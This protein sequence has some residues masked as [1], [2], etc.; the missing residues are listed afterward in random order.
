VRNSVDFDGRCVKDVEYVK[1]WS[2]G[3]D[4]VIMLKTPASLLRGDSIYPAK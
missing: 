2:L 3:L 1:R 4:L